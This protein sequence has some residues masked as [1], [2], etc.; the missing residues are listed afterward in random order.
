MA[1]AASSEGS[2]LNPMSFTDQHASVGECSNFYFLKFMHFH[3][4][5]RKTAL[6]AKHR[7]IL[8]CCSNRER[9]TVLRAQKRPRVLFALLRFYPQINQGRKRA[10]RIFFLRHKF[11]SLIF[12]WQS[13]RKIQQP[14]SCCWVTCTAAPWSSIDR[15][16]VNCLGFLITF[17]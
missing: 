10:G 14:S 9:Q 6:S 7:Q 13:I 4:S 12:R 11:L 5:A 15:L 8:R 17:W 16:S 1:L 3:F 2:G